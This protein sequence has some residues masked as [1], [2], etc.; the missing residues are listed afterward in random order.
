MVTV[1][2]LFNLSHGMLISDGICILVIDMKNS[3]WHKHSNEQNSMIH[4]HIGTMFP[5]FNKDSGMYYFFLKSS[6]SLM[7]DDS[8]IFLIIYPISHL[9][10]SKYTVVAHFY[11]PKKQIPRIPKLEGTSEIIWF[12]FIS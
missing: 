4:S 3:S 2:L 1:T 9:Q 8:D 12:K 5:A 11:V 6:S 10:A 7:V